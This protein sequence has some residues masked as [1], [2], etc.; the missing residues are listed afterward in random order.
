MKVVMVKTWGKSL[1]RLRVTA[2]GGKPCMLKCHVYQRLRAARPNLRMRWVG[3]Q[4]DPVG[5]DRAR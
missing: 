1:R 5:N 2:G 4:I 3:R